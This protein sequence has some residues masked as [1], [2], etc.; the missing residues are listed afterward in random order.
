MKRWAALLCAVLMIFSAGAAQASTETTINDVHLLQLGSVYSKIRQNGETLTAPTQSLT[1]AEGVPADKAL[2][3]IDAPRVGRVT[4]REGPSVKTAMF[5]TCYA[6]WV[7]VVLKIGKQYTQIN[8]QGVEGYV[9]T[10]SLRFISPATPEQTALGQLSYKGKVTGKTTVN[11]RAAASRKSV[12]VAT[13]ITGTE[14]Y[15][16]GHENGWY[17]VEARGIR[18][19]V[20]ERYLTVNEQGK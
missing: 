11:L 7:V 19:Y 5:Y 18:G 10:S 12:V 17:E 14:V 2:A 9:K 15:I 13:W 1:F 20:Q 6:G 3:V 4:M 8:Y 16:L